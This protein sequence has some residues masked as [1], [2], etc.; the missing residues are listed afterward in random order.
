[1]TFR[2]VADGFPGRHPTIGGVERGTVV[3]TIQILLVLAAVAAWVAWVQEPTLDRV[4]V[5]LAATAAVAEGV[6]A[7]RERRRAAQAS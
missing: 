3:R 7:F 4:T 5:A 1:M 2:F 6:S